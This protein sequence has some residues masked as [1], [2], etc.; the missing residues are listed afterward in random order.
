MVLV[1][2]V[3]FDWVNN[4]TLGPVLI[5][6]EVQ[7]SF[8]WYHGVLEGDRGLRLYTPP[9]F[10]IGYTLMRR[11]DMFILALERLGREDPAWQTAC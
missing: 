7:S 5:Y 2:L 6:Y 9:L 3:K 8:N 10:Q 1:L 11:R 4:I